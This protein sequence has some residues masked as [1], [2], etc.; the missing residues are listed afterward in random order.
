MSVL[1]KQKNIEEKTTTGVDPQQATE[2]QATLEVELPAKCCHSNKRVKD[3][4]LDI[5]H[6]PQT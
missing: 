4:V 6:V 3:T 5:P 2:N 1:A